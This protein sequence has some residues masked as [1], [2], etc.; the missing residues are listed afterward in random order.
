MI[1][2]RVGKRD[3]E[4]GQGKSRQFRETRRAGTRDRQI[5]CAVNFLHRVMKCGDIGGDVFALIIVGRETFVARTGKMDDLERLDLAMTA[6][7]G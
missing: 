6:T 5:G 7:T 4:P 1:V 2:R 3:Q